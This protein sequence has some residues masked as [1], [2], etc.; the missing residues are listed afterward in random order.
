MVI[1]VLWASFMMESANST[2]WLSM[3][4]RL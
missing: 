3:S 1:P 2:S 4:E